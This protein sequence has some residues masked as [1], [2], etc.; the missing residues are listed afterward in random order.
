M[1]QFFIEPDGK[2]FHAWCPELK[3]CHSHGKTEKIAMENLKDAIS[4]YLEDVMQES[5]FTR[6]IQNFA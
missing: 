2:E 4:L 5:L 3:G 6:K 1:I